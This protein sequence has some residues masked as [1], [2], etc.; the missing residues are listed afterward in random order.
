MI[1]IDAADE[2]LAWWAPRDPVRSGKALRIERFSG[3]AIRQLDGQI[4]PLA[5]VRSA[6]GCAVVV[7]TD[8]PWVVLRLD[9]LRHHQYAPVGI[10]AEVV[11]DD[12]EGFTLHSPD[13]RESLGQVD[14]RFATGLE[15]GGPLRT[16]WIWL[17]LISTA[18]VTGLRLTR[19]SVLERPSLPQAR[20]LAIG[21]SLTQGFVVQQPTQNW[22]HRVQM[23]MA[24][25]AWNLGVGG[26]KIEPD[27]FEESLTA[28]SWD[29][30]T[31]GL[32]SNHSWREMDVDSVATRAEGLLAAVQR[33]DVA[34]VCWLMPPW[35][36]C[37]DGKGPPHFMGVPLDRSAGG[38]TS[39]IR[40]ILAEVLESHPQVQVIDGLMPHDERYFVDGLHPSA[41]GMAHY[42]EQVLAG[43]REKDLHSDS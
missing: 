36:P 26:L 12:G 1:E 5:N 4:G 37:E 3:E 10:D 25:P 38:R 7:R 39:R 19:E 35:K 40:S 20:W 43:L 9:R 23:A 29:L 14:V 2:R 41:L 11:A 17:P 15:R 31:I 16:V 8:S 6:S 22:V 18:V 30:L 33:A 27:F 28:R 42:A 24:L 13:L 21:D 34:R 32:G